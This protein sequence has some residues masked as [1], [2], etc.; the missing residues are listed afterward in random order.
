MLLKNFW[1]SRRGNFAL[2]LALGVPAILTAVAFATDV[3]TLMK[4][5]SNLQN[6]LDAANLA[7]SHLGD[8][9]ISRTP[10]TAISRPTSRP[11]ANCRTPRPRSASTR[12][13]TTSR[14]RLSLRPTS[15]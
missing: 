11:T 9:D 2:M 12:A 8:I 5:K 3:S 10:S 14:P 13:S 7:S 4:A 1:R 6:A 15:I